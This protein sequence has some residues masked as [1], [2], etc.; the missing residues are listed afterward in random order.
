[1]TD[2]IET[3]GATM[4]ASLQ[5]S[6]LNIVLT[7][8]DYKLVDTNLLLGNVFLKISY[9]CLHFSSNIGLV[10]ALQD[11]FGDGFPNLGHILKDLKFRQ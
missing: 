3:L 2:S 7:H 9:F 5:T 11:S 4:L 8:R 1:M 10:L 6:H